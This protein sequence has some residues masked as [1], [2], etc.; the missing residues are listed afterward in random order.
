MHDK[1]VSIRL[2]ADFAPLNWPK[3]PQPQCRAT[4]SHAT[5]PSRIVVILS[6]LLE[7]RRKLTA[8]LPAPY[9]VGYGSLATGYPS[10]AADL[11]R[12]PGT[13][14]QRRGDLDQP[15]EAT[16]GSGARTGKSAGSSI[17]EYEWLPSTLWPWFSETLSRYG[18]A[19][20]SSTGSPPTGCGHPTRGSV[21]S[22]ASAIRICQHAIGVAQH[23]E[24]GGCGPNNA[25]VQHGWI[26][27]LTQVSLAVQP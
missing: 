10:S 26:P 15:R 25:N 2:V 21:P 20:W 14:W 17:I 1:P 9:R 11:L 6:N 24:E 4:H 3:K 8:Q 5:I 19:V 12:F 27:W 22:L 18:R 7:R 13:R 23:A 16:H